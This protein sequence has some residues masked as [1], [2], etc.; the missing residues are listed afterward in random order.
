M[1]M[2]DSVYLVISCRE[3]NDS[4]QECDFVVDGKYLL[5]EA[6]EQVNIYEL[7]NAEERLKAKYP[8]NLLITTHLFVLSSI[9][10]AIRK[11]ELEAELLANNM[12]VPIEDS[13]NRIVNVFN[14]EEKL[15]SC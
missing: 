3:T 13:G 8:T 5:I 7:D 1:N 4:D 10:I 14:W 9:Q 2:N 15:P 6:I 12:T 11:R